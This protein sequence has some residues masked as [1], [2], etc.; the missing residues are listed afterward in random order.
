MYFIVHVHV[1]LSPHCV[2]V[3]FIVGGFFIVIVFIICCLHISVFIVVL[4]TKRQ[5]LKVYNCV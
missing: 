2:I 3:S 4:T 1:L 5:K